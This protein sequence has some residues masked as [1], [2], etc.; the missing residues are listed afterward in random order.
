MGALPFDRE[1]QRL[2]GWQSFWFAGV[3]AWGFGMFLL[4][5]ETQLFD[6][7]RENLQERVRNE[8]W[9]TAILKTS[10][11][12]PEQFDLAITSRNSNA[13]PSVDT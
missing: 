10:G 13:P 6:P 3:L 7:L 4:V 8:N 11:Q 1:I 2:S 12:S 9:G 5:A